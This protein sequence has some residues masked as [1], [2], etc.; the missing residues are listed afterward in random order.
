MTTNAK[1]L[2]VVIDGQKHEVTEPTNG[3]ALYHFGKVRPDYDLFREV[4]GQGDDELIPNTDAVV[5]MHE[6]DVFYS[7][8]RTLNPGART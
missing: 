6:G 5:H 1:K 7:A 4:R 8:K 3:A 2:V